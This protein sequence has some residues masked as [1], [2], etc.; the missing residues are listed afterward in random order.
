MTADELREIIRLAK[1]EWAKDGIGDGKAAANM[2]E[3]L[4]RAK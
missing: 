1:V 3:I 2:F 4:S